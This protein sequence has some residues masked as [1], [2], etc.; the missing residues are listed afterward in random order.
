MMYYCMEKTLKHFMVHWG[1]ANGSLW[2]T[3]TINV[4]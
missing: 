3:V 4:T 2:T 1:F